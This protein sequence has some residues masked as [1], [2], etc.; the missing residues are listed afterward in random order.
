MK[1]EEIREQIL[2][3]GGSVSPLAGWNTAAWVLII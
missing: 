1:R 3:D 2:G